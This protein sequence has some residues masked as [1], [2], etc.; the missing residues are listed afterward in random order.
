MLLPGFFWFVVAGL[1]GAGSRVA[2]QVFRDD[3]YEGSWMKVVALGFLGCVG[4]YI[5]FLV[6]P[7][8]LSS[9]SLGFV[10]PDVIE[11]LASKYAPE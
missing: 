11:N 1:V 2:L 3:G 5:A 4:G 10:A 9:L 7:S 8:Y 6:D